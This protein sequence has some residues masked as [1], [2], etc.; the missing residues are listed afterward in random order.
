LLFAVIGGVCFFFG[1]MVIQAMLAFWT[2]ETLEVMNTLTY[3]GVESAQYPLAIYHA[4]FRRFFTFV[5]PLACISYF[6]IVGVLGI[7]D[8][9]GSPWWFQY[10]S[11]VCGILF[12]SL[13]LLLWQ[14]GVKH[15]TST[16]S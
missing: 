9:L 13:C 14:C 10:L 16:G 4:A 6:P 2:T 7:A 3:G 12:L 5:V 8:P 1:L 11:P 15:Y